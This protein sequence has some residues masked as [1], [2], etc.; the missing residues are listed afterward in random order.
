MPNRFAASDT[1]RNLFA[2]ISEISHLVLAIKDQGPGE[3]ISLNAHGRFFLFDKYWPDAPDQKH[4]TLVAF[5]PDATI[6]LTNTTEP[7]VHLHVDWSV[8]KYALIR[9][10]P[11]T[12]IGANKEIVLCREKDPKKRVLWFYFWNWD[13]VR[14]LNRW[15][16]DWIDLEPPQI[17]QG[18]A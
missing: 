7:I 16:K 15:G 1:Q 5:S 18:H 14:P 10:R 6:V 8:A 2:A 4:E 12:L 17:A 9:D 11:M 3:P 13:D